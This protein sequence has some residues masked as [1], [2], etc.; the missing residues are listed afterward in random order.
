VSGNPLPPGHPALRYGKQRFAAAG[1]LACGSKLKAAF[2]GPSQWHEGLPLAAYSC[3]GSC[4]FGFPVTA[5][6][7]NPRR[8]GTVAYFKFAQIRLLALALN[9]AGVVSS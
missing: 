9:C 7:F 4:G 8:R 6:P 1:L 3:G 5:F 2:P